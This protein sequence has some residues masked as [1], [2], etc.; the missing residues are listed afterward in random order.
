MVSIHDT[1]AVEEVRHRLRIEP[2]YLRQLRNVLFKHHRPVA[3]A[4]LELPELQ[5]EPFARA[6]DFRFLELDSQHDSSIDGASKLVFRTRAGLKLESVILRIA[7]GRTSLCVSSQVGCAVRCGFCAT[8]QMGMAIDLTRDEI[9]DQVVQ[10][11]A[12]LAPEN[13][14]VR[15]VV[16][17]GMGEPL[18]TEDAVYAAIDVLAAPAGFNLT[19]AR[20]LVSTV[21]IPDAMVRCATRYPRLGMALSLHSA[22]QEVRQEIIPLARRYPLDQLRQAIVDVTRIQQQPLMIEYLLLGGVNDTD[23]DAAAL[24]DYLA[25]LSVSVNLIPYNPIDT[26]RGFV[27]TS[28]ARRRDFASILRAAG[29]VVRVRYSL[30]ADIAAACGQLVRKQ[31]QIPSPATR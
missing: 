16:F 25:G 19:P 22:R 12:L 13:R 30:G 31:A 11:N 27:A 17:M 24:V 5:R 23:A 15:N 2:N 10:A 18:L 4:L 21:G 3:S 14:A 20:L 8:G 9:L 28:P 29:F 26:G 6:V 1:A 7:T